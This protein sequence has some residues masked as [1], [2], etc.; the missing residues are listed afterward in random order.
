[1]IFLVGAVT[2]LGALVYSVILLP[3]ALLRFLL[4][5]LTHSFYRIRIDGRDNIPEKGGALFVCN[6]VSFVDGPLLMASTDRLIRFLMEKSYYELR[7]LNPFARALGLIPV[8]STQSP[9]ELVRSLRTAGDAIRA[10]HVVCIFAEGGIT[11]TGELLEF[12]RGFER[13]MKNCGRASSCPLPS[14][15]CG[16]A[17]SVLKV[18]IFSGNGRENFPIR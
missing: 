18:D 6:H 13:I 9:R 5:V 3:D 7:W 16:A 17:F 10:G 8:S 1:M 14:W 15:A 11:R 2:V 4:W 12:R